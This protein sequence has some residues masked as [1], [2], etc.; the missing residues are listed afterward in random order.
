M[1]YRRL[2]NSGLQV[3]ELS[4]GTWITFGKQIS[5][6]I[7]EQCM[8]TAYEA[9][10]NFFDNA[11]AYAKGRA[12]IVMGNIL[13][14]KAWARETF[15]ISSK[16]FFGA[17]LRGPNQHGLSR[18]HIFEACHATLKRLNIDYLDLYFCH[19]PD[20]NTPV[21]ETVWAMNDLIRQGKVLYWG[22][23]EWSAQQIQEAVTVARENHILG[24]TMEQPEYNMFYRN[25]VEVEYKALY[26][27]IGL[28]TTVWSPLASG[29]LTGKYN[30]EIP[31]D[32]RISH[33]DFPWLKE[34]FKG[35]LFEQRIEKVRRLTALAKE[36]GISMS[37]LALAWCLKN[38]D[39]STVI[40]GS[41][42]K[43]QVIE[44]MRAIDAVE[45]L[46]P[47]VMENIEQILENKPQYPEQI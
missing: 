34:R 5:D 12:E 30:H 7:A 27:N 10:V 44:N 14:K 6:D 23:S 31:A 41:S 25:R 29:L 13:R 38:T 32:T 11:E 16:V 36:L 9:G 42:R 40:T 43:E 39:V 26:E 24:P 19:R 15:V 35:E 46:E 20:N 3:S 28:G 4:F 47:A 1:N 21:T 2:G 33:K 45:K 18:K 22:T 8:C 37:C 17:E